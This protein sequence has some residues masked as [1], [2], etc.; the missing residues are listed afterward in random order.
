MQ[1]D[2]P[3]RVRRFY[4]VDVEGITD[5]TG[6]PPI[7]VGIVKMDTDGNLLDVFYESIPNNSSE[8]EVGG[9]ALDWWHSSPELAAMFRDMRH[10]CTHSTSM[11]AKLIQ[12]A[13]AHGCKAKTE[14]PMVWSDNP[15]Y[16]IGA[17]GALLDTFGNTKPLRAL[18]AGNTYGNEMAIDDYM[19]GLRRI[20]AGVSRQFDLFETESIA[21][22]DSMLGEVV[23]LMP[24]ENNKAYTIKHWRR[25]HPVW[26]ALQL[27]LWAIKGLK[28]LEIEL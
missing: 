9:G 17:I 7:A 22:T 11:A 23:A 16:D 15:G 26:D 2:K 21:E 19:D 10:T 28:F 18:L 3:V 12:W 13:G 8:I 14:K 27:A 5:Y 4:S 1:E 6:Q 24:D 20:N 25:H